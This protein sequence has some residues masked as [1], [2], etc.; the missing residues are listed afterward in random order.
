MPR[1]AKGQLMQYSDYLK[2]SRILV[3]EH[4]DLNEQDK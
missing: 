3:F 4:S 2:V 1:T